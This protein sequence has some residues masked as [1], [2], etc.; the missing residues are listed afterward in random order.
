MALRRNKDAVSNDEFTPPKDEKRLIAWMDKKRMTGKPRV[1]DIS[2]KL[3]LAFTLGQQWLVWD[4]S[5]QTF[6]RPQNRPN[7]PNAPIRVTVNKI[8]PLIEGNTARLTKNV[9]VPEC[10]PVGDTDEDMDTA[11]V[12]TRILSHECDRLSWDTLLADLYACWVTPLGWSYLYVSWDPTAGTE[13]GSVDGEPVNEGE[14]GVEIVPAFEMAMDPNAMNPDLSDARWCVRSMSMSKEAI[15]EAYGQVPAGGEPGRTIADE[16]VA[17]AEAQTSN[18]TTGRRED[19]L[20]VHQYW[21]RPGS[22]A[23]P[24]G[25]VVTWCGQTILEKI[26][27]FPYHHGRLPFVQFNLLPGIG[28]REGRTWVTDLIP[29]QTDYNDARSREAHIR[30]TMTPKLLAPIGSIDPSRVNSRVE[31]LP[32]RPSGQQPMWLQPDSRSMSQHEQAMDRADHEMGDRAGSADV[33]SGNAAA[34][35]PAAAILALQEADDTKLALS[36]KHMARGIEEMGRMILQLAKQF[37]MEERLVRTWSEDHTIQVDHFKGSDLDHGFDVHLA[38]ESALPKS[39]AARTQLAIDL[40]TQ[41][42]ITDPHTYVTMLDIPGTDFLSEQLSMDQR[43]A[44][45]ENDKLR[46]GESMQVQHFDDHEVHLKIHNN[47]RKTLDYEELDEATRILVDGHCAIHESLVLGQMS[48]PTGPGQVPPDGMQPNQP[49]AGDPIGSQPAY[50]NAQ[51]GINDP[52]MVASGQ[53]PS[54][55]QDTN[56]AAKAGIG[57]PSEPG[58]VPN[59][60]ADQ[61]AASMGG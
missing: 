1:S 5:R 35:M 12:G 10:R 49:T 31:V 46:Q 27:K 21:V 18:S 25:M 29:L 59:V 45:R 16:V 23:C 9:P 41:G 51:G 55:L 22:R 8:A 43:R 54:N 42:I 33:S 61:Q 20:K 52:M 28:M 37:W 39:K 19:F 40:W 30:R 6:R 11:K 32:Y 15:Y 4:G 7:D 56:I 26:D 58:H 2:M 14:I 53:A 57:G 34:S 48:T 44:V 24:D 38:S 47:F 13:V 17:L 60:G 50:L 36:A 3:N